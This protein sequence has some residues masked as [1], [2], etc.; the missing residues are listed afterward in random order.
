MDTSDIAAA[1]LRPD[2]IGKCNCSRHTKNK[3]P[4]RGCKKCKGTGKVKACDKCDGKRMEPD[5][6]P[7][8]SAVFRERIRL[9]HLRGI[10]IF[11]LAGFSTGMEIESVIA[12]RLSPNTAIVTT[13]ALVVCAASYQ[14]FLMAREYIQMQ[15]MRKQIREEWEKTRAEMRQELIGILHNPIEVARIMNQIEET[16]QL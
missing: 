10:A 5:A 2:H 8:M 9:L 13:S 15:R 3:M 16:M 6:K 14:L 12:R 4:N 1:A 11:A 7:N